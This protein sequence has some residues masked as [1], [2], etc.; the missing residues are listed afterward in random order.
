MFRITARALAFATALITLPASATTPHGDDLP[1]CPSSGSQPTECLV[2]ILNAGFDG[3]G[4]LVNWMPNLFNPH[5]VSIDDTA[6]PKLVL[7]PG[8]SVSQVVPLSG[9][10]DD[11]ERAPY[12]IPSLFA[13]SEGGDAGIEVSVMLVGADGAYE[14]FSRA[15]TV[16]GVWS[17]PSGGFDA[18]RGPAT[19]MVIQIVRKD[20]N[21]GATVYIDDVQ[22]IRQ[23]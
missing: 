4:S 3:E 18:S 13:R 12:F 17:R 6:N 5:T 15:Y 11:M 19:A 2:S 20:S 14:A 8:G 23:R 22:V 9:G 10:N 16:G 1:V 7:A 21:A